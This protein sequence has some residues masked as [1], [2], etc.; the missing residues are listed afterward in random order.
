MS[1][2]F[3]VF[4]ADGEPIRTEDVAAMAAVSYPGHE[5]AATWQDGNVALGVMHLG[6]TPESCAETLPLRH[7]ATGVVLTAHVRLDNRPE[8]VETLA[9][10]ETATDPELLLGAYLRWGERFAEHLLGDFAIGIWDPR[11]RKLV[12][13]RDH[14]GTSPMFY[15]DSGSWL[16]FASSTNVLL[17]HPRVP[18]SPNL[19]QIA[20]MLASCGS[21]GAGTAYADVSRLPAGHILTKTATETRVECYWELNPDRELKF[22]S[23]EECVEAFLE[24]YAQAVTC[25]LRTGRPVGI[26][27]SAGLDSGSV[28]AL[29]AGDLAKRNLP[30]FAFTSQPIRPA[31]LFGPNRFGDESALVE[32]YREIYPNVQLT[33]CK[34]EDVSPLAGIDRVLAAVNEPVHGASNLFWMVSMSNAVQARHIGVLLSGQMGNGTVS[35]RV[36]N[37]MSPQRRAR[38]LLVASWARPLRDAARRLVA[39]GEPWLTASPLNREFAQRRRLGA[40]RSE[41]GSRPPRD[42]ERYRLE[43][44]RQSLRTTGASWHELGAAYGIEV[45]DPTADKRVIEFCLGAPIEQFRAEG[46][47][48]ALL[49]RAMKGLMPDP[50]RLSGRRG[51]Q[52]ADLGYRI[53]A[54]EAEIN[55]ALAQMESHELVK[56]VLDIPKM[57][58]VL[59]GLERRVDGP[60]TDLAGSVLM[61]GLMAGRF[62]QRF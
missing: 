25:R 50:I 62:L 22:G 29:A 20:R 14:H 24:V 43:L 54:T 49:R 61:R 18:R 30:L 21:D 60:S 6:T 12:V 31:E 35:L 11:E 59:A 15:H 32:A 19:S 10:E 7:E 17:A 45:L 1:I 26:S 16:V 27:L 5:P 4:A 13:V 9:L 33:F 40:V 36:P 46:M 34:A 44:M 23:N 48:R 38:E 39:G 57:R 37:R 55:E 51:R 28:C 3:G 56:E 2:V 58:R 41:A 53:L 47:D 42:P 52:A 8:L